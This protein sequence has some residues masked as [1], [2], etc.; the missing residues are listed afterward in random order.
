M[1]LS[2]ASL[3]LASPLWGETPG[4]NAS[5]LTRTRIKKEVIKIGRRW[6]E[7][8]EILTFPRNRQRPGTSV[9][10][11]G[12]EADEYHTLKPGEENCPFSGLWF[13][14]ITWVG[15]RCSLNVAFLLFSSASSFLV[16]SGS[17]LSFTALIVRFF[18]L[19]FPCFTQR[20]AAAY[21]HSTPLIVPLKSASTRRLLLKL[22]HQHTEPAEHEEISTVIYI[23]IFTHEHRTLNSSSQSFQ[24]WILGA[25]LKW[26]LLASYNKMY[27]SKGTRQRDISNK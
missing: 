26:A 13:K 27:K 24:I 7:V 23:Y 16:L 8:I 3:A 15:L 17:R 1:E 4:C 9:S 10:I 20:Q 11:W 14:I 25:F 12:G 18:S 6:G 5:T 21:L 19:L 22:M 2:G